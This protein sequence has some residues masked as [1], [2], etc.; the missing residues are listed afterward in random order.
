M[1]RGK[2][3]NRPFVLGRRGEEILR[4]MH[5][6]RF[7]TALD[8]CY[9]MYSPSSLNRVRSLLAELSGGGDFVENQYLYRFRVPDVEMGTHR[10]YTLGSRGRDFLESEFG[11]SSSWYFRP[12]KVRHLSYSQIMHSLALS[13]FLVAAVALPT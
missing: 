11:I 12:D 8:V 9:L 13:R 1:V 2:K 6:Y 3:E 5:F 7:M 10:V 4:H